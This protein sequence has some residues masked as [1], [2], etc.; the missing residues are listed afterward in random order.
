MY[1]SP[2]EKSSC[3]HHKIQLTTLRCLHASHFQNN[4]Q[5]NYAYIFSLCYLLILQNEQERKSEP[6]SK[7]SS[8]LPNAYTFTIVSCFFFHSVALY[9]QPQCQLPIQIQTEKSI[10]QKKT[11]VACPQKYVSFKNDIQQEHIRE[12]ERKSQSEKKNISE[13]DLKKYKW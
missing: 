2:K 6:K 1:V 8:C 10:M 11:S 3:A 13:N 5:K 9:R 12:S 7:K 4:T